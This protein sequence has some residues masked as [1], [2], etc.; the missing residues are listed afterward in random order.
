MSPHVKVLDFFKDGLDG[1]RSSQAQLQ[2][3][4]ESPR[5]DAASPLPQDADR[6]TT[7][8]T[9]S[10]E[11]DTTKRSKPRLPRRIVVLDASFNP[12]TTAH[13]QM[14]TSAVRS[15]GDRRHTR[16]LLLLAVNN[17]DKAPKPASFEQ[18]LAMMNA[19][20][21]EVYEELSG[22]DDELDV[23]A[24]GGEEDDGYRF[25][26]DLAL[27]TLPYFHDKSA[28]LA[29][30][31]ETAF[32]PPPAGR[33]P[34]EQVFLIGYDTLIRLFNPK[35]YSRTE[36]GEVVNGIRE[37]LSPLFGRARARLT[38]RADADWGDR[39]EQLAYLEAVTHGDALEQAGGLKQWASRIDV[40]ESGG[41]PGLVSSTSAR[42]AATRGDWVRLRE[43]V[44]PR[45]AA[46]VQDERLYQES[47]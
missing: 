5:H 39:E 11:A 45:V 1:F 20:A 19:L 7:S 44:P 31:E 18:R 9:H 38:L 14:A 34:V 36:N 33:H 24:S 21:Q 8:T 47:E 43:L 15:A 27:T 6:T 3:L 12:P 17:A 4:C 42:E 2:I 35:Y 28:A 41:A 30:V 37:A 16:L 32:D 25:G 10:S 23:G 29:A 26:I 22:D 46:W 13:M 40:A